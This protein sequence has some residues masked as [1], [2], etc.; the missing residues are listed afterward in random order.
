MPPGTATHE[1][2]VPIGTAFRYF[3]A[4]VLDSK[5]SPV[6]PGDDGELYVAGEALARGYLGRSGLTAERFVANPFGPAG[7]RMYRTGDY[8]RITPD[9]LLEHL[10]RVDDQVKVRGFRVE[11]GEI[12]AALARH[13]GV[14]QAAVALRRI[15]LAT[16][17][18]SPTRRPGQA[19]TS[20]QVTF[21]R[22]SQPNCQNTWSRQ[23]ACR[24]MTCP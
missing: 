1:G 2:R 10:G 17:G 18:S 8:V 12:E 5:L 6:A 21:G 4:H 16:L 23:P 9:G 15:R 11:L 19:M 7:T 24:S 3:Q 20:S 14:A 13:S 22:S